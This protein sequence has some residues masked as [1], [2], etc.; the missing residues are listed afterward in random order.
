MGSDDGELYYKILYYTYLSSKSLKI[1][2]ICKK[3]NIS[4]S[5]YFRKRDDA[6]KRFGSILWLAPDRE[7]GLWID[8]ITILNGEN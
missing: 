5:S 4:R 3:L 7:V 8:C 2:D 1:D 6:I